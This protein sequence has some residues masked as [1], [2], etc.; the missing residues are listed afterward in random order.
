MRFIDLFAGMGGLRLGFENAAKSLGI[1]TECVATSE[2][3][4]HALKVLDENF[5]HNQIIGD[6]TQID[7]QSLPDF[8]YL[9]A[10]I[11]CQAFSFSG[12]RRGFADTRGTLFFDVL[13]IVKEKK[14]RGIIIENVEGLIKH[15]YDKEYNVE[16]GR[17]LDTM[18]YSLEKEGYHVSW[19]LLNSKDFAVAQQRKRIFIVAHKSLKIDI[20]NF[21]KESKPLG[22]ILE[23]G[24]HPVDTDFTRKL[25]SH[26]SIEELEGKSIKDKRGGPNNI[27][28]WD[29]DL[30]GETT[31]KQKQL[32]NLLFKERRKKKWAK[33]KGITWMDGM[34]LTIEEISTF[35]NVENLEEMLND[36]VKKKYLKFE[37][38]KDLFIDENLRERR[39]RTDLPK[40]YNIVA[41]KLSFEFSNILDRKRAT[42][43][44]VATDINKIGVIDNNNIRRLTDI[45]CKRLFG[46][47]DDFKI[48][49]STSKMYDLFGNT[50]VIPVVEFVSKRL[51]E[52]KK[53]SK[54]EE[55]ENHNS[56]KQLIFEL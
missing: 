35:F 22:D 48:P 44:L 37:H 54:N 23:Q 47:P 36:L 33:Q 15:D 13:R 3:K 45:E 31:A 28:S 41:G 2:I 20:S 38:P 25:L 32:M 46:F 11:P 8:D 21:S 55:F 12:K 4:P 14:P 40:G 52:E 1:E 27:H 7:E 6:I 53:E 18:I 50:V 17:T 56:E 16:I 9:L 30:K 24:I 42:Q 39:Y 43:T 51:L 49:L 34:P 5:T 19:E 10:G 29:F 26:Y